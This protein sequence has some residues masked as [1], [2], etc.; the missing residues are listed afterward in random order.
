MIFLPGIMWALADRRWGYEQNPPVVVLLFKILLF[1]SVTY[2]FVVTL[3][4][5]GW[6]PD[7]SEF[8]KEAVFILTGESEVDTRKYELLV[9]SIP[10]SAVLTAI[11]LFLVKIDAF[12]RSLHE[13]GAIKIDQRTNVIS[14]ALK[15][16]SNLMLLIRVCDFEN[17]RFYKGELK[18]FEILHG[19]ICLILNKVEI[20][21]IDGNVLGKAEQ[22]IYSRLTKNFEFEIITVKE[23]LCNE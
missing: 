1:G 20:C 15:C 4:I 12:S 2:G 7:I 3:K 23:K 13:I 19:E 18:S 14:E 10:V 21:G 16:P 11:W 22:Y 9:Y 5:L 6:L 8:I 17:G